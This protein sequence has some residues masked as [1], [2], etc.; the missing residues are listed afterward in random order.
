MDLLYFFPTIQEATARSCA[1][2]CL[3]DAYPAAL[4]VRVIDCLCARGRH[5]DKSAVISCLATVLVGRVSQAQLAVD[6][7]RHATL[8][9]A[10]CRAVRQ[11]ATPGKAAQGTLEVWVL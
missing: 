4:A 5:E 7:A 1:L 6:G 9:R 2:L 8:T 11:I 3:T 10:I